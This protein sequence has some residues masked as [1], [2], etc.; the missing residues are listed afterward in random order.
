M[1]SVS[2]LRCCG[3]IGVGLKKSKD[4]IAAIEQAKKLKHPDLRS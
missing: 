3:V 4:H 2:S 1:D